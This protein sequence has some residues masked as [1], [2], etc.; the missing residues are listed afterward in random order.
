MRSWERSGIFQGV[1]GVGMREEGWG[2]TAGMHPV[3]AWCWL[4]GSGSESFAW[5]AG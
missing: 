3:A 1:L 4:W 5:L 2:G